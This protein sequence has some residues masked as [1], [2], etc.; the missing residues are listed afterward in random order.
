MEGKLKRQKTINE[1][2]LVQENE[3]KEKEEKKQKIFE[4]NIEKKKQN[5]FD[6]YFMICLTTIVGYLGKYSINL[7]LDYF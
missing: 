2:I 1:E 4:E 3:I 7:L 5:K 6:Y